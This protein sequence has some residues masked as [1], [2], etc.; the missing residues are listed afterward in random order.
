MRKRVFSW[1]GREFVELFSEARSG[2]TVEEETRELL[3][4]FAGELEALDLSL[5]NTV[6]TRLWARTRDVRIQASKARSSILAGDASASSS[7]YIS[8]H[9]FDSNSNVALDLLSMRPSSPTA[10]RKHV[11]FEPPRAYLRYLRTDSLVFVS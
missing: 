4:R 11:Q 8:P 1:L 2:T 7:S 5:E 3:L 10:E 9:H 6:R